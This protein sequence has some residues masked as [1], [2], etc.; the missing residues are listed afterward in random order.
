MSTELE[1]YEPTSQ[2]LAP[3]TERQAEALNKKIIAA[4]DKVSSSREQLVDLLDKAALGQIHVALGYA[5]WTAWFSET[6]QFRPVDVADRKELA[7]MMASKGMS[8]RAS[9]KALDCSQKTVSRDL[10]G[11]SFGS[12]TVTS[13]NGAQQPR[14]KAAKEDPEP[15]DAEEV[16]LPAEDEE[17]PAEPLRPVSEDFQDEMWNLAN[18]RAAIKE[19]LE[20][21]R[22]LV[23]RTRNSLAKKH[24]NELQ[25]AAK[26]IQDVVDFLMG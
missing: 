17:E 25:D 6:V 11:E 2:A 23:A 20:D 7:R 24:T 5:S 12:D 22:I 19:I 10:Q 3:L 14:H 26:D 9:A 21:E 18:W 4:S 15:L 1:T 16:P 8:T 13:L